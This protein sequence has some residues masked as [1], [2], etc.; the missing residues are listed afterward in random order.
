MHDITMQNDVASVSEPG[1][2]T[3]VYI[4]THSQ[5]KVQRHSDC[6]SQWPWQTGRRMCSS[7]FHMAWVVH[8]V[9]FNSDQRPF[10][11]CG[12]FFSWILD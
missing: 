1:F 8:E 5:H 12:D 7:K 11:F 6:N 10:S 9:T 4:Q 2:F 3:S